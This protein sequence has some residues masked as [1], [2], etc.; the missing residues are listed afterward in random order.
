MVMCAVAISLCA[1]PHPAPAPPK[2]V[3]LFIGNGMGIDAVTYTEIALAAQNQTRT[4]SFSAFTNAG[5]ATTHAANNFITNTAAAATALATGHKTNNG[6]IAMSADGAAPYKSVAYSLKEYGFRVG[7]VTSLNINHSVPAA[8]YAKQPSYNKYYEIARELSLSGFDFIAGGGFRD[9]DPDG[10]ISIVDDLT[11][12]GYKI[13]TSIEE[14]NSSTSKKN[15]LIQ[16][17]DKFIDGLVYAID[18][19]SD[20]Y[21]LA[22]MTRSAIQKLANPT[23]F[24]LMVESAQIDLAASDNDAAALVG[25]M[26]EFSDAVAAAVEFYKKHPAQTLIIVTSTHETGGLSIYNDQDNHSLLFH[27]PR[28]SVADRHHFTRQYPLSALSYNDLISMV[29]QDYSNN[30]LSEDDA[31]Q[32]WKLFIIYAEPQPSTED[33]ICAIKDTIQFKQILAR[34]LSRRMGAHFI[35]NEPTA[36]MVPVFAIGAGSLAFRGKMDNTDIPKKIL[37]AVKK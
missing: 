25:E 19:H 29:K 4:M 28:R 14:V 37:K 30:I 36:A 17:E 35:A 13:S 15:V 32:L 5:W 2:Y 18:K 16:R 22:Q 24:F 8:F 1:H 3:F 9:P 21:T 27:M 10:E 12:K 23:G 33:D 11:A 20:D 34:F 6:R 26:I 7:I 31:Y